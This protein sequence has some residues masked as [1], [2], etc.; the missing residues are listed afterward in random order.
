MHHGTANAVMLPYVLEFNREAVA[1]PAE[2]AAQG[3]RLR[4][5]GGSAFAS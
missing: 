1:G 2:D 3:V 4:R 5:R